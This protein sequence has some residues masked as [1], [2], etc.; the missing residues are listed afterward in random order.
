MTLAWTCAPEKGGTDRLLARWADRLQVR[1]L[2]LAGCVQVN[3][4]PPCDGP[5]GMELRLLPGGEAIRI[6]QD[7]GPGATGCRLDTG[8]L[9]DAVARV[10]RVA[11]AGCDLMIVNKFGRHEETGQGFRDVIAAA[12]AGGTPVLVGVGSRN[13]AAFLA[14]ADG[15]A[16]QV[17]PDPAALDAWADRTLAPEVRSG[18][19]S[20]I[21]GGRLA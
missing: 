20:C 14:F 6:S 4:P 17:A 10:E 19:F 13:A 11:A 15:L 2:R 9:Q 21:D 7:L 18:D 8:A 1:G 16:E 3:A 5:C 12:V